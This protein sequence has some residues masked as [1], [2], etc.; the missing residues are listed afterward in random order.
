MFLYKTRWF[1]DW[2]QSQV[3]PTQLGAIDRSS[4][5]LLTSKNRGEVYKLSP[6]EWLLPVDG[7]RIQYPKCRIFIRNS[8]LDTLVP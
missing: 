7:G 6:T 2:I 1:G 5:C 8:T 3:E 4:L